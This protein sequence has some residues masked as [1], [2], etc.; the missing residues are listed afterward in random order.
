MKKHLITTTAA[1]TVLALTAPVQASGYVKLFGGMNEISDNGFHFESHLGYG[2]CA[3]YSWAGYCTISGPGA[4]FGIGTLTTLTVTNTEATNFGS[5]Y[6]LPTNFV[7]GWTD[8]YY[9]SDLDVSAD[10]GFVVGAAA[11]KDM[12]GG[13]SIE[14]EIAYRKNDLNVKGAFWFKNQAKVYNYNLNWY[15]TSATAQ[16][17][18]VTTTTTTTTTFTLPT[19][20]MSTVNA[21]VNVNQNTM[22]VYGAY[23]TFSYPTTAS[24]LAVVYTTL[25]SLPTKTFTDSGDI[26]AFSIMANVWYDF[27][28]DDNI[29]PFIGGGVGYANLELEIG[30]LSESYNGFAWQFGAGVGFD[31]S[32]NM[33]LSI[34]ARYF[35]VPDAE[36]DLGGVMIPMAYESKEII[37]GLK[38]KF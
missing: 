11:G 22:V 19:P 13:L 38:M 21:N 10:N 37:V 8:Q 3:N 24:T 27:C 14:G 5:T 34:E 33:Q 20:T 16:T 28:P 35:D 15:L 9:A 7:F 31:V 23:Y 36:F 29:H 1:G 32:E 30:D 18:E 26:T 25:S 2:S 12:G 6:V 17:T 4:S